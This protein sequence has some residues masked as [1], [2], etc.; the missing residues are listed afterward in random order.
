MMVFEGIFKSLRAV[1]RMGSV[2]RDNVMD[3]IGIKR[4]FQGHVG[5][6]FK[7]WW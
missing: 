4:G 5:I 1:K 6:F 7:Y 3:S 2:L